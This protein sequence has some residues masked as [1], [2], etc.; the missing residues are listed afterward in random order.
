MKK[1]NSIY[2]DKYRDEAKGIRK[3]IYNKFKTNGFKNDKHYHPLNIDGKEITI[4]NESLLEDKINEI[5]TVPLFMN[6]TMEELSNRVSKFSKSKNRNI[7]CPSLYDINLIK[8]MRKADDESSYI[9]DGFINIVRGI[10][11]ERKKVVVKI[12]RLDKMGRHHDVSTNSIPRNEIKEKQYL[13]F[14][15]YEKKIKDIS[16]I[17]TK[18]NSHGKLFNLDNPYYNNDEEEQTDLASSFSKMKLT[19]TDNY[20]TIEAWQETMTYAILYPELFY[21]HLNFYCDNKFYTMI[22]LRRFDRDVGKI[23]ETAINKLIKKDIDEKRFCA[24]MK[25]FLAQMFLVVFPISRNNGFRHGDSKLDNYGYINT[26]IEY[27]MVEIISLATDG[28]NKVYKIPTL[29]RLICPF[30]FGWACFQEKDPII[31]SNYYSISS[32][33][34]FSQGDVMFIENPFSDFI[35]LVYSILRTFE[36]YALLDKYR[37]G[38]CS[39]SYKKLI[40]FLLSMKKIDKYY[41]E[42]KEIV[43]DCTN[44][45]TNLDVKILSPNEKWGKTMYIPLSELYSYSCQERLQTIMDYFENLEVKENCG[46]VVLLHK[47]EPFPKYILLDYK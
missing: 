8:I 31:S 15:I 25:N 16:N 17:S 28:V 10:S 9:F 33:N 11:I 38:N 34:S 42:N 40:K 45:L 44:N 43:S 23:I 39:S 14:K 46:E 4:N 13:H 32:L 41:V 19:T 2:P 5:P 1:R 21:G 26:D 22:V 27:L 24:F 29:D 30:D 20:Y 3:Y 36:N 18:S 12:L 35:Q 47:D 6:N 37:S 7:E